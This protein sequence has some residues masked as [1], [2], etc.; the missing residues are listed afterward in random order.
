VAAMSDSPEFFWS[1]VK[2]EIHRRGQERV[3]APMP[4]VVFADWL[5]RH[6]FAVAAVSALVVAATGVIWFAQTFQRAPAVTASAAAP[7]KFAKVEQLNAPIPHTAAT[8]FDSEDAGVTVIWVTGLPWTPDMDEM[9]T[10]FAN[11]DT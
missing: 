1:K 5:R 6:P 8:A 2:A 9:K 10:E 7:A 3:E 11:L 4:N